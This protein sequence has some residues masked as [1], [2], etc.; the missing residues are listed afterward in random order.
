M[1]N[2]QNLTISDVTSLEVAAG[3][4]AQRPGPILQYFTSTGPATFSVPSG[5]T[6]VEV[7]IVAGGGGGA[8]GT[9]GAGSGAGGGAGGVVYAT[10]VPV[11]P[12]GT[13][14][15]V[16][17][18]GGNAQVGVVSSQ[19]NTAG[20]TGSDSSFGSLVASGGGG[21]AGGNQP[22]GWTARPGGSGGG[23]APANNN[24]GAA[25]TATQPSQNP[26]IANLTNYGNP[27][28]NG[29]PGNAAGGGGGVAGGAGSPAPT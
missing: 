9:G 8:G 21:G 7:L 12:G 2:L 25:G 4:S 29:G 24:P 6:S 27:G 23:G 15:V 26:G 18:A 11:T 3:T 5:V 22:S 28:G 14:P 13:V 1:A 19:G 20:D 16:V 17:G 10:A